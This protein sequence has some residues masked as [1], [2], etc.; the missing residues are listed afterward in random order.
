M[1]VYISGRFRHYKQPHGEGEL[2]PERMER[3]IQDEFWWETRLWKAG[4]VVIP[5]LRLT[6]GV[7]DL[8]KLPQ[9]VWIERDLE[10]IHAIEG[11]RACI[12]MRPG[13]GSCLSTKP[14]KS[15]GA[16]IVLNV[17]DRPAWYR[18]D[19]D[20]DPS[21]GATKEL[22]AAQERGFDV[23]HGLQGIEWVLAE[24]ARKEAA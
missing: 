10:L 22:E 9:H 24:I 12:L 4:H 23:L 7:E 8:V 6:T 2:D 14:W 18:P 20:Y 19:W 17:G 16:N 15:V 3:E 1:I 11:H 5:P 13:W 21:V